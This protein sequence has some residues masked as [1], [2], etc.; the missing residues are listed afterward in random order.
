M[1]TIYPVLL[2]GGSG[3]RLWPL[4]RKAYP[5]Q[6]SVTFGEHSLFQQSALR[7]VGKGFA[8]PTVITA[9]QYRFVAS[10]QL[11]EIDL[12]ANT[13]MVEPSAK[14]TAPAILAATLR[15]MQ[16]NPDALLLVSPTDHLIP[17]TAAFQQTIQRATAAAVNDRLVTFGIAPDRPETGYGYLKLGQTD[18]D[19]IGQ[20]D[21]FVEKPVEAEALRMLE[22]GG[23]LWNAGIFMFKGSTLVDAFKQHAPEILAGVKTSL[24]AAQNDLD[25]SRLDADAWDQLPSISIDYAIMEQVDNL[26]VVPFNSKW[27]DLGDWQALH[28]ELPGDEQGNVTTGPVTTIDC[29]N[30]LLRAESASQ[31]VVG[32][33]LENTIVVGL[34]D[35]VLVAD[36]SR[37]QEV[38]EA[39]SIL[40]ESGAKQAEYFLRDDRPWGWYETLALSDRFQVKRIV[41]KPGGCLSLQSHFHRSEHWIVV[42]GTARITLGED[43]KLVTENESVYIPLGTV[44]RMENPGKLPMV[45]IEVQTGTYLGEDDIVRYEDIYAR[46]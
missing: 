27:S 26:S 12:L 16:D 39:V 11:R 28:R 9:E 2:C 1:T 41:V 45:L 38:K 5:K 30:S 33:G 46:S 3:T 25:F 44:H 14:N 18:A 36:A 37:A 13:L 8:S 20:L 34:P 15:V 6:F 24:D 22:A 43:I 31:H 29:K 23:Y 4:S 21:A 7:T 17:N 10:E 19:G 40:K 35:A 42:A 32:I